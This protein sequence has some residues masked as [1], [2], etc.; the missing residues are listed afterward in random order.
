MTGLI[1]AL[2]L[3]ALGFVALFATI[4][5]IS[6]KALRRQPVA[7]NVPYVMG[8]E[9]HTHRG[10]RCTVWSVPTDSVD[11]SKIWSQNRN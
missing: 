6:P 7:K 10:G 1:Y 11:Y 2:G 5:C 9:T 8:T 4:W 3:F